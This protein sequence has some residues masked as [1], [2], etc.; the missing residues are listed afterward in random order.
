MCII[1]RFTN[2]GEVE[3]KLCASTKAPKG[4]E[5]CVSEPAHPAVATRDG[6]IVLIEA[7]Q[8]PKYESY[9]WFAAPMQRGRRYTG[10]DEKTMMRSDHLINTF[11]RSFMGDVVISTSMNE[12]GE[13]TTVAYSVDQYGELVDNNPILFEWNCDWSEA[14]Y[15]HMQMIEYFTK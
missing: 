9:G 4:W 8:I 5:V 7:A 15:T 14:R 6:M 3:I 2:N 13:W 1:K 12:E 10:F 11:V